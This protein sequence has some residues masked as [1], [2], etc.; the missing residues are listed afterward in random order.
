MF[1]GLVEFSK[2]PELISSRTVV[3][4]SSLGFPYGPGTGQNL[5]QFHVS[6]E[7]TE[8]LEERRPS[9]GDSGVALYN[10]GPTP[11]PTPEMG[12]CF[13]KLLYSWWI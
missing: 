1:W 10:E 2:G 8:G 12:P 13:S 7:S 6:V 4:N 11:I 9:L 5:V 3:C